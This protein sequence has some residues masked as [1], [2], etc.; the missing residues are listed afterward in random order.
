MS[1]DTRGQSPVDDW[2]NWGHLWAALRRWKEVQ[3]ENDDALRIVERY[4]GAGTL[5]YVDPPYVQDSRGEQWAR[6]A[7]EFEYT[8]EEHRELAGVLR[9]VE[10]MV[11]LSG[12]HSV[13][14]DEFYGDWKWVEKECHKGNGTKATEVLWM[15]GRAMEERLPLLKLV[16]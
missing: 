13:L 3:I 14:Y 5:F 9:G 15:N 11:V 12:Y 2:N 16:V 7:Y 6:A 10:G 8:G 4:D 1:K